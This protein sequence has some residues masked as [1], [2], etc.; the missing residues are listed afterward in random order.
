MMELEEHPKI[1]TKL[2]FYCPIH[3]KN[4]I[5]T[6]IGFIDKNKRIL[7]DQADKKFF[8]NE[9]GETIKA[10]LDSISM[11]FCITDEYYTHVQT[12]RR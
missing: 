3:K 6:Q 1:K 12:K 2:D 5:H 4:K 8:C 11:G 9:C 10:T 7:T